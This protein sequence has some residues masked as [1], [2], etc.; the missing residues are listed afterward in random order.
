M[1]ESNKP[2]YRHKKLTDEENALIDEFQQSLPDKPVSIVRMARK[3]GL[4][5]FRTKMAAGISG[6]IRRTKDGYAIYANH[7]ESETRR[8]FTYAHE[9]A[10]Y[11]LHREQIGDGIRENALFRSN[12]A[13]NLEVE[14]NKIAADI[15]V[16]A[17][18]L[19][20]LAETRKYGVRE[21]AKI[22]G[23]SRSVILIR[24]GIPAE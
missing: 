22:F 10:H 23:V 15:L 5:V 13:N 3:F 16:P 1:T 20:E 18:I 11:L 19:N 21:L 6:A 17:G 24:L 7:A 4:E 9:L 2:G 14:A 8:R 12:L